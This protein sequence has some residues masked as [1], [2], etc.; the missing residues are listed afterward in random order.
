MYEKI[1]DRVSGFVDRHIAA[2]LLLPPIIVLGLIIIYPLINLIYT[3]FFET[4]YF[5]E[6]FTGLGNYIKILH[7]SDFHRYFLHS[8]LYTAGAVGL[9]FSVGLILALV[10]DKVK[11]LAI[12][13]MYTVTL[14]LSWAIPLVISGLIWRWMLN[15]EWGIVNTI[16]QQL[17][18]ITEPIAWL[19]HPVLVWVSVIVVDAWTRTPFGA[20]IMLA[21]LQTIPQD[22]YDAAKVDGASVFRQF[23]HVTIP[24]LRP[25]MLVAGLIM[26]MFAFRTF[27][28]VWGLTGT[29]PGDLTEIYATYIHKQGFSY[30]RF[31]YASALSVVMIILTMIIAVFYVRKLQ[32]R[33]IE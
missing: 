14:L 3:S 32:I 24:H 27:S 5:Q 19:S 20:I 28:I 13:N 9:S 11:R 33:E 10:L 8:C 15:T 21:G 26:T 25:S 4:R 31:G 16:L 6:Q 2:F 17:G 30:F 7:D 18:L 1:V 23:W 22:L 29:G 12:R